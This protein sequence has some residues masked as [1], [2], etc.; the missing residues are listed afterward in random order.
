M[1]KLD[2]TVNKAANAIRNATGPKTG[3]TTKPG[4]EGVRPGVGHGNAPS[5]HAGKE[6]AVDKAAREVK[7]RL[8]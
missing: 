8:K 2:K 1:S 5:R 7:K 4:A 3:G 6:T